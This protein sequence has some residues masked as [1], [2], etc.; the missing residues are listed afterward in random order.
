MTYTSQSFEYQPATI[1]FCL[2]DRVI[3]NR[4]DNICHAIL[5]GKWPSSSQQFETQS[6]LAAPV[7]AS[8][9]GSRNSFAESEAPDPSFSNG[10]LIS[11]V[12]KVRGV[13]GQ[14]Q[15][16]DSGVKHCPEALRSS[17]AGPGFSLRLGATCGAQHM[18]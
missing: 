10:V 12:Q 2:Q 16:W 8:N 1:P 13:L 7:V 15:A 6:L 4:I 18:A 9:A 5:K 11:Q 14:G 17:Q 3:I